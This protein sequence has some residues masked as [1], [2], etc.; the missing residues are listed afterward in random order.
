MLFHEASS[1]SK[2]FYLLCKMISISLAIC[3]HKCKK[4]EYPGPLFLLLFLCL[5]SED[6]LWQ[7]GDPFLIFMAMIASL[8]S[9]SGLFAKSDSWFH[10]RSVQQCYM[11]GGARLGCFSPSGP[12]RPWNWCA[13]WAPHGGEMQKGFTNKLPKLFFCWEKYLLWSKE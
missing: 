12:I 13:Q 3:G 11:R 6:F 8:V 1:K 4:C 9:L 2:S 10:K 7:T 5:C